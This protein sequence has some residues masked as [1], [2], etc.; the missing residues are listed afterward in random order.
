MGTLALRLRRHPTS[1]CDRERVRRV[2][3][4]RDTYMYRESEARDPSPTAP[5]VRGGSRRTAPW[6]VRYTYVAPFVW[7]S[8]FYSRGPLYNDASYLLTRLTPGTTY[9]YAVYASPPGSVPAGQHGGPQEEA[10]NCTPFFSFR[11]SSAILRDSSSALTKFC[12]SSDPRW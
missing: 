7:G 1:S 3:C 4:V 12:C 6:R 11:L 9:W 10:A 2:R 8:A 5:R